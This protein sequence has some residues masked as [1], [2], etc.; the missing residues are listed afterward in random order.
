MRLR[1]TYADI[2][3]HVNKYKER[4][5]IRNLSA[6]GN[7]LETTKKSRELL[8]RQRERERQRKR[9]RETEWGPMSED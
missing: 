1:Q 2:H 5:I 4:Q 8:A 7:N 9:E 6:L 3:K